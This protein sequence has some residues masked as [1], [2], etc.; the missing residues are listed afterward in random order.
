LQLIK[1][2]VSVQKPKNP[3]GY[4]QGERDLQ[5]LFDFGMH[6]QMSWFLSSGNTRIGW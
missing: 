4:T 6:R 1:F 5:K 3:Q 2:D